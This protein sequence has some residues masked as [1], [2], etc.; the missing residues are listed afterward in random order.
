MICRYNLCLEA[1]EFHHVDDLNKEFTV[2]GRGLEAAWEEASKKCVLL[3]NRCHREV[4]SGFHGTEYI[5][6]VDW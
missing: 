2:S 3:C 6:S 4:H 1:L 5:T